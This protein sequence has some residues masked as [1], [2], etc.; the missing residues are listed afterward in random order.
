L[1][2][3]RSDKWRTENRSDQRRPD[4]RGTEQSWEQKEPAEPRTNSKN[5]PP[6]IAVEERIAIEDRTLETTD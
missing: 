1:T 4:Q 2:E 6:R 5:K 3:R